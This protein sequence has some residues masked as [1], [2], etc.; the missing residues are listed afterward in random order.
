MATLRLLTLFACAAALHPAFAG[1]V[2][3]DANAPGP[4]HDGS[5]WPTAYVQITQ[6]L[7]AAAP[8]D[9]VWVV[10]GT[11]PENITIPGGVALYGG[12]AGFETERSQRDVQF[13]ATVIDGG[14]QG[15]DAVVCNGE[16]IVVDGFHIQNGRNGV[17]VTGGTVTVNGNTITG[18]SYWGVAVSATS[19]ALVANNVVRGTLKC[20]I[21]VWGGKATLINNTVVESGNYAVHIFYGATVGMTNNIF[22]FGRTAGVG[23]D[24]GTVTACSHNDSYGNPA[25]PWY[26]YTP[27][28]GQ[29][30]ITLDPLFVDRLNGD[31]RLQD[32]SP[33]IDAGDDGAVTS[34]G[35][36]LDGKP[37]ILG[38]RVDIGAYEH[39]AVAL[40]FTGADVTRCLAIA[41]GLGDC[42]NTDLSRLNVETGS[43]GLD[44][45]DV[46]RLARK[47]AGLEPNP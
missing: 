6:G 25:G 47:V 21:D 34:G 16:G 36:D 29:G 7:N 43:P 2:R 42:A 30:N 13:N 11:Y 1:I 9:E 5:T 4:V 31:L 35:R 15:I 38:A 33:C 24:A 44:L 18:S 28:D 19:T 8:G 14:T 41:S 46:L 37:R 3:V 10:C 27:P 20:G 12:F 40:P 39:D 17:N 45:R 26:G 22:A 32:S 23:V